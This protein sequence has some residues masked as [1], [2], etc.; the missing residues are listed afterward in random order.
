MIK[1]NFD[2]LYAE[3]YDIIY[4][5]KNYSVEVSE[6]IKLISSYNYNKKILDF[7]CGTGKH[8]SYLQNYFEKVIGYDISQSMLNIARKNFKSNKIFFT[9]DI[10]ELNN[11]KFD[12]I[13]SFF[14]VLSY[15]N[16]KEIFNS[17]KFFENISNLNTIVYVQFWEKDIVLTYP[18]ES[19]FNKPID[20]KQNITRSCNIKLIKILNL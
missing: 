12:V 8:I 10:N 11:H 18:P 20:Q 13:T 5:D 14:D 16:N 19:Y 6:L 7:G 17:I 3:F 2:K 1:K 9:N 4:K 15:L